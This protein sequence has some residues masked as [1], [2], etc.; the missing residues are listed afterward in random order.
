MPASERK[1]RIAHAD[2]ATDQRMKRLEQEIDTF[3]EDFFEEHLDDPHFV[4]AEGDKQEPFEVEIDH[5]LKGEAD[6]TGDE[7]THVAAEHKFRHGKISGMAKKYF[8]HDV[9]QTFSSDEEANDH[10]TFLHI[11]ISELPRVAK[12]S[13]HAF[14]KKMRAEL[15]KEL[16]EFVADEVGDD[17]LGITVRSYTGKGKKDIGEYFFTNEKI[18]S[19]YDHVHLI[20]AFKWKHKPVFKHQQAGYSATREEKRAARRSTLYMH[21]SEQETNEALDHVADLING[22]ADG[23][24]IS[25]EDVLSQVWDELD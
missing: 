23:G 15:S 16:K 1:R 19:D 20:I 21:R 10:M 25:V 13:E 11:T 6:Y 7:L 17:I 4:N 2:Y 9:E 12:S 3:L 24:L 8:D 22:L 5:K 18:T 14:P